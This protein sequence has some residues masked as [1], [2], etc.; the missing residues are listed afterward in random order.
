M[1]DIH[2]LAGDVTFTQ[3][4]AN[5]GINKHG[6]ISVVDMDKEYKQLEYMNVIGAMEHNSLKISNKKVSLRAMQP[7]KEN[8]V[9]N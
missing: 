8:G 9:G 4:T 6:E 5:K 1:H 3:M 7:I 2:K